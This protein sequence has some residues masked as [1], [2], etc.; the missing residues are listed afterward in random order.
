MAHAEG[1]AQFMTYH[2][3]GIYSTTWVFRNYP[4]LARIVLLGALPVAAAR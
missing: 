2:P 4:T 3:D 1:V